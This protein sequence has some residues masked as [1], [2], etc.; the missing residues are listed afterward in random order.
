MAHAPEIE[1][2]VERRRSPRAPARVRIHYGTVDA[3][4]SEF[5]RNVNEG[6]LFVETE[7]VLDLDEVVVLQ[8]S[9]PETEVPVQA[10]G[11]VVRIEPARD[12]TPG[13]MGIE[14]EKLDASARRAID[15]LVRD[16]RNG[17][18]RDPGDGSR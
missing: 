12:G 6:G 4:F 17:A 9:L 3:L 18:S 8:F 2:S 14:F 16:L 13:G 10:R 1:T 11:R 5:T 15:A 7:H